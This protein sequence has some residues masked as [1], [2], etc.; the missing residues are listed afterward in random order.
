MERVSLRFIVPVRCMNCKYRF[1]ANPHALAEVRAHNE[2]SRRAKDPAP[3]PEASPEVLPD[4]LP[5]KLNE[6]PP[7]SLPVADPAISPPAVSPGEDELLDADGMPILVVQ[8][9]SGNGRKWIAA[10]LVIIVIAAGAY[11]LTVRRAR[12]QS[13]ADEIL[14]P[15]SDEA[16]ASAPAPA[17]SPNTNSGR[18]RLGAGTKSQT[19]INPADG[20]TYVYISP[21]KFTMGCS[22]GDIYCESDEKPH[23]ESI[24]DGF[25]LGQT[26]VTQ[27]AWKKANHGANPSH[28]KGDDLPV[29]SVTWNDAAAFCKAVGG[30][31]P[32]EMEWEYAARAETTGAQYGEVTDIAWYS[33]N[34]AGE[35][36][37]VGRKKAN[38]FGLY[39]MLGNVWEWTADNYND[40]RKSTRGGSWS[41]GVNVLRVSYRDRGE[42]TGSS[43]ILG[44]RCAEDVR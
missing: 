26:E 13:K 38:G 4:A 12:S 25:W 44:L 32:T 1:T 43:V 5:K 22:P 37:P 8:P 42:P 2:S 21:G 34:S 11:T 19:R 27:A 41:N 20:L 7:E 31:L 15:L 35:T 40:R 24:V 10:L 14:P 39:D 6:A 16:I 17:A 28:F 33:G 3:E 18:P 29:E 36:H 9:G 23:P 30:R